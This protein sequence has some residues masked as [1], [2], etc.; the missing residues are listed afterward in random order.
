MQ[1][2][3]PKRT[4][5]LAVII[6]IF[7]CVALCAASLIVG[8]IG[9]GRFA[10]TLPTPQPHPTLVVGETYWV[11]ALLPPPGLPSGLVLRYA[12]LYNKPGDSINDPS[13][14]I[15]A[16]VNDATPVTLTGIQESWCY[17]EATN[18]FGNQVEGWMNCDRLLD[19]E[20]TPFPT[21]NLTPQS[22]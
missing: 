20:P 10:D 19:Y 14:T 15:V 16:V 5:P 7:V 11:G 17:V 8:V 6:G 21:L 13:I 4:I 18:E 12:D 22:P 3:K 1:Q 2:T 9:L